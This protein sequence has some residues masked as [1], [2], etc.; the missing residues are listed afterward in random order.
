M[1]TD[2]IRIGFAYDE[3]VRKSPSDTVRSVSAEYEDARTIEWMRQ[4]YQTDSAPDATL[5]LDV[6]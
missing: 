1:S 3:P 5:D 2:D 6:V 4:V